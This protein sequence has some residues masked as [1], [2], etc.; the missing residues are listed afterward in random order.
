MRCTHSYHPGRRTEL[1]QSWSPDGQ[2]LAFQLDTKPELCDNVMPLVILDLDT[3]QL[4]YYCIPGAVSD[5]K[6]P[7]W[8]LD[9]T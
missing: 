6:P 5:L 9:S 3:K 8:S 7:I 4:T 2:R 1:L